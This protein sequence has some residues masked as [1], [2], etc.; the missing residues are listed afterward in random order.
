MIE[1]DMV[2][3]FTPVVHHEDGTYWAEIPAMPGCFTIADTVEEL[4][5]N[6]MEAMRCWLETYAIAHQSETGAFA[7]GMATAGR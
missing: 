5:P 2:K 4:R 7:C 1:R 6:L 3:A